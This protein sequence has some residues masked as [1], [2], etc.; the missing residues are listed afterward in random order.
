MID[1]IRHIAD[2]ENHNGKFEVWVID[3][4][5]GLSLATYDGEEADILTEVKDIPDAYRQANNILHT[6]DRLEF[7]A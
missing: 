4:P 1:F 7:I 5:Y 6:Q 3:T 2:I